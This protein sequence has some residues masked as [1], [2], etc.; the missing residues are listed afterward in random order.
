MEV[1]GTR[2]FMA[3]FQFL[4]VILNPDT[5][6]KVK[7]LVDSLSQEQKAAL[8]GDNPDFTALHEQA[9]ALVP[10]LKEYREQSQQIL[11]EL[12]THIYTFTGELK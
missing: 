7:Q 1:Y 10:G 4:R 9:D 2:P 6:G 3:F 8:C 11:N 12:A 5:D